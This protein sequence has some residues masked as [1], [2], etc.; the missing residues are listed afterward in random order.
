[1]VALHGLVHGIA[2]SLA[3]SGARSAAFLREVLVLAGFAAVSL[4]FARPILGD[5]GTACLCDDST[6]PSIAMWSLVW[7]PHALATGTN[8]LFTDAV[9][10]PD[11]SDLSWVTTVPS[12]ALLGY[13]LLRV[14]GPVV[15]YN[16]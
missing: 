16:A 1:M 10:A 3:G 4:V 11:G 5:L 9:W 13:P 7:W 2:A 8:P 6:D 12:A 14:G 15:A